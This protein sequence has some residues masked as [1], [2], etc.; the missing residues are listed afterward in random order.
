MATPAEQASGTSGVAYRFPAMGTEFE[1]ASMAVDASTAGRA[2]EDAVRGIEGTFSRFDPGS[3]LCRLNAAA[4]KWFAASREMLEVVEAAL[5]AALE[6]DGLFNPLI[7]PA[8]EAAGYAR[9]FDAGPSDGD[10]AS[11]SVPDA[12]TILLDFAHARVCLPAGARLDLGGIV[13]GWTVD[14]LLPAVRADGFVNAGGDLRAAG[15]GEQGYGW[16]V[17]IEDPRHPARDRFLVALRDEAVATSGT[18]RRRWAPVAGPPTASCAHH[19][20]DPRTAQPAA[21]DIVTATVIAPSCLEAEV[22]AKAALLL[23]SADGH[24]FLEVRRLAAVL[25]LDTGDWIATTGM[26]G[27]FL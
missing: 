7:L 19:L 4:G 13:K 16:V 22:A 9:T 2:V 18:D 14:R 6:T 26:Q 20:I 17:G 25:Q 12:A 21:S 8:L 27:R 11:S 10:T 23:G 24:R 5:Q 15:P 1:V 3:E